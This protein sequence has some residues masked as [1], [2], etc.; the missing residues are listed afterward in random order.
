MSMALSEFTAGGVITEEGRLE[1]SSK[2]AFRLG[3]KAM[4]PGPVVLRMKHQ[5]SKRTLDQNAFLHAV[6]FTI[7]ADYFGLSVEET[8][9][10][11]MGE[12]FGWT[13]NPLGGPAIPVKPSTSSMTVAECTDF[14]DWLIPWALEKWNVSIPLPNEFD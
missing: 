10:A 8:K 9:Y 11:L 1:L 14:I 3:C 7:L 2:H 12:K 13:D 6:P 5:A 4:A